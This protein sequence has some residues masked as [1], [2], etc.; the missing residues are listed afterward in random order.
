MKVNYSVIGFAIFLVM[1]LVSCKDKEPHINATLVTSPTHQIK[2]E[3]N[4][5]NLQFTIEVLLDTTNNLTGDFPDI[6]LINIYFDKN[7]DGIID[8]DS[9]W[10]LGILEYNKICTFYMKDSL[11][12]SGCGVFESDATLT[13]NFMASSLSTEEHI[14]WDISIPK[15]DLDDSK[16]LNMVVKTFAAGEGYT[17][18]P[19]DNIYPNSAVVSFD[20]VLSLDW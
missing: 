9:D 3:E 5:D 11:A 2:V 13:S 12:V 20:H 4:D 8:E 10:G 14:I 15:N 16:P 19:R 17:T 7:A 6:D 18:F 1:L